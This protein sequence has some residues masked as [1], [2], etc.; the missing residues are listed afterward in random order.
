MYLRQIFLREVNDVVSL[1]IYNCETKSPHCGNVYISTRIFFRLP[2]ENK[3]ISAVILAIGLEYE[4]N[5]R[6]EV[7]CNG[8]E[9]R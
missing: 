2:I 1:S 3:F 4:A 8:Y 5:A 6:A 9:K 7:V